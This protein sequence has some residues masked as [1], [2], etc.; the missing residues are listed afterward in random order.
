VELLTGE[1][2][3]RHQRGER[4]TIC[5]D[6]ERTRTSPTT[7]RPTIATRACAAARAGLWKPALDW[8][9]AEFAAW[10][11]QAKSGRPHGRPAVVQALRSWPIDTDPVGVRA[12][13]ARDRLP[14][15][16]RAAWQ[17][18]RTDVDVL[19]RGAPKGGARPSGPS[20]GELPAP[21]A[22]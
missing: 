12:R 20:A 9:R 15:A 21:F 11:E 10:T 19:I 6:C 7:V 13:D 14:A 2:L 1:F 8:L 3:G 22:H 18:L 5:E 17:A 16:E 4:S